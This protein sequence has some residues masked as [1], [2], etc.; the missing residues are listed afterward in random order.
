MT[1]HLPILYH[2]DVLI[3]VHK[4]AGLLVHRT[5]IDRHETRFAVQLVRDQIGRHVY[6]VHRLDKGTSG[7]LLFALNGE[8]ARTVMQAF[9]ERQ[10]DKRYWAVVR[11]HPAMSGRIEHALERI[12][13]DYDAGAPSYETEAQAAITDFR[14]LAR[15]ELPVAVDRYPV[16]RY[17]LLELRPWT[18]RRHQLR[19]HLKHIAHPIIGDVRYGKGSHN[20]YFREHLAAPRMLLA[21]VGMTLRHPLTQQTLQLRQPVADSFAALLQH[22]QWPLQPNMEPF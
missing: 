19:R 17:A 2:D 12:Q 4:P 16:S 14:Q 10:V 13:D 6:P 20:R 8:V 5:G 21:C 22:W 9:A 1:E 3:A 7:I 11:G 15:I 18:G